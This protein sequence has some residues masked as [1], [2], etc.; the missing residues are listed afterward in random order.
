MMLD[1]KNEQ[2]WPLIS[3]SEE[4]EV[5]GH[6]FLFLIKFTDTGYK[7]FPWGKLAKIGS[8]RR[9]LTDEGVEH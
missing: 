4:R 3:R 6:F 7:S 5:K 1:T 9:F 8:E 2:K